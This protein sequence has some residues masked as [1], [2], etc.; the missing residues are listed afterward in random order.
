[1]KTEYLMAANSVLAT[2]T[3]TE[4]M[5]VRELLGG[6]HV[7]FGWDGTWR[8]IRVRLSDGSFTSFPSSVHDPH[9]FM[10]GGRNVWVELFLGERAEQTYDA[11][12]MNRARDQDAFMRAIAE[13]YIRNAR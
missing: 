3:R 13:S 5:W 1:M 8:T 4:R 6:I 11:I 7:L 12:L 10:D 9:S 2:Y